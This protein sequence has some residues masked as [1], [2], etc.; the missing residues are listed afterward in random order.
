MA[1][2]CF[3]V[4]IYKY[5]ICSQKIGEKNSDGIQNYY[6]FKAANFRFMKNFQNI[7]KILTFIKTPHK[8]SVNDNSDTA[9]HKKLT[10]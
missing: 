1:Y 9:S 8:I 7:I 2:T 4:R 5:K 6:Y 3:E 10:K